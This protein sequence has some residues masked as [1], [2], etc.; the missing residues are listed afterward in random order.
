MTRN[1]T[2]YVEEALRNGLRSEECGGQIT[3][4]H[5]AAKTLQLPYRDRSNMS[6][7]RKTHIPTRMQRPSDD[8]LLFLYAALCTQ[9]LWMAPNSGLAQGLWAQVRTW[10]PGADV[11]PKALLSRTT[12]VAGHCQSLAV[13]FYSCRFL[14]DTHS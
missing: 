12:L 5:G 2:F 10:Q 1:T 8:S 6:H 3:D 14:T 7:L 13:F 9:G 11:S 4:Q